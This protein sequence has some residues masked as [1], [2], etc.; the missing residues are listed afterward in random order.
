[1][2][3]RIKKE[4]ERSHNPVESHERLSLP[5]VVSEFPPEAEGCVVQFSL[6]LTPGGWCFQEGLGGAKQRLGLWVSSPWSSQDAVGRT[7][8]EH[9][10]A[11]PFLCWVKL[12]EV[13][14]FKRNQGS[15]RK[16]FI[17]FLRKLKLDL[18]LLIL[19]SGWIAGEKQDEF[20][21]DCFSLRRKC[22]IV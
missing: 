22:E 12:R 14:V 6:T 16:F 11:F 20:F 1:M 13:F 19:A 21:V 15:C 5:L 9:P 3:T 4:Q 18:K 17:Q 10:P 7:K 2:L 8:W